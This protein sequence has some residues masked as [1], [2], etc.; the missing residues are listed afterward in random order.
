MNALLDLVLDAHGGLRRWRAART[1]HTEGSIG[2]LLWSLRGQEEIF[3]EADITADVQQQRLVFE[4]F[5][6]PGLRGVFTPDRVVIEQKD[7]EVLADRNAPRDAFAGHRADTPWDPLHALYFAG[8]AMWNYLTAPYL[9][10]RPGVVVEE[11]EFWREPDED[12]R[13]LRARFPEALATHCLEQVFYYDTAGLLRR[14]D[15]APDVLGGTPAAHFSEHHVRASGLVFPTHRFVV[16]VQDDGRAASEP[17]L[18]TID[19]ADI[20]VT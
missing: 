12:W 7:C 6:D 8:Y 10:T 9:L 2:G 3:A 17:V 16:P 1:I 18:I 15:Y 14:H 11:L 4:G 19:L 13:R 20:S 5:T